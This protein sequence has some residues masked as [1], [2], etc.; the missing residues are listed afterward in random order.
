[1]E[2]TNSI[3]L[4]I[5]KMLGIAEEYHAF[6]IDIVVNINSVF[7]TLNQLG[8]GPDDPYHIEGEEEM[9]VDFLGDTWQDFP[10]VKTYV[11]LK[12]RLLFDPPTNSFLVDAM[13]RQATEFEWRLMEQKAYLYPLVENEEEE[14]PDSP[15]DPWG[16]S[17][18]DEHANDHRTLSFR[19]AS[20]QHP[21]SAI[22]GLESKLDTIPNVQP[23]SKTT[24]D[25]VIKNA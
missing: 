2:L 14:D 15:D 19:Q 12:T 11:Y 7:L 16:P 5:K 9:W 17:D 18:P 23:I 20:D 24:I 13:Q 8:V 4:T 6:D 1:M 22:T 21:I 25:E 3:L 10:G